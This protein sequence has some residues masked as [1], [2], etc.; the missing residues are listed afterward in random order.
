M[1]FGIR[2]ILLCALLIATP[3][4]GWAL[5]FKPANRRHGEM[6]R[7]VSDKQARLRKLSH[8][9]GTVGSLQTEIAELTKAI[10]YFR[11]KLPGKKGI[12]KVLRGTWQ[13]AKNNGLITK[14]IRTI[15]RGETNLYATGSQSEQP[16][17]VH[18]EGEFEG[19]YSFL[20]ALEN[21][22]RIMRISRMSIKRPQDTAEGYI[23]VTFDMTVFFDSAKD[24]T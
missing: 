2:E 13:L 23:S 11:A 21:Q 10:V 8:V 16:V 3:A 7:Q 24:G 6:R 20:Q 18:L 5:V 1:R 15:P 17:Q 9:M 19:F 22:P 14:S 4:A 12:H